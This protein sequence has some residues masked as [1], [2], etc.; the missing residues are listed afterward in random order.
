MKEVL[1]LGRWRPQHL[2][3]E[4]F[5]KRSQDFGLWNFLL[6][7]CVILSQSCWAP[8]IAIRKAL[9]WTVGLFLWRTMKQGGGGF[10]DVLQAIDGESVGDGNVQKKVS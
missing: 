10:S 1:T 9:K 2:L 7:M 8:D 5:W 3:G 4:L 6:P